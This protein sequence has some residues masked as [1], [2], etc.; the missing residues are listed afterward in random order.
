MV[1]DRDNSNLLPR[2][3]SFGRFTHSPHVSVLIFAR[4]GNV[5]QCGTG[6][7]IIT[8][9]SSEPAANRVTVIIYIIFFYFRIYYYY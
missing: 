3:P 8:K 5:L 2:F 1:T 9:C 6:G 4:V 7:D